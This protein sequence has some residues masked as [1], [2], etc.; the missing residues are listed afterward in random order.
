VCGNQLAVQRQTSLQCFS[1]RLLVQSTHCCGLLLANTPE[2]MVNVSVMLPLNGYYVTSDDTLS[3][4]TFILVS[5][6]HEGNFFLSPNCLFSPQQYV[7]FLSCNKQLQKCCW[8]QSF[9]CPLSKLR[10]SGAWLIHIFWLYILAFSAPPDVTQWLT[11]QMH[12]S[13][14]W[15][16]SALEV[17]KVMF[18]QHWKCFAFSILDCFLSWDLQVT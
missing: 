12:Y 10:A 8:P 4:I 11:F 15:E 18:I 1:F 14:W 16:F 9:S 2:I 17:W 6:F 7:V 5:I 3:L 13:C